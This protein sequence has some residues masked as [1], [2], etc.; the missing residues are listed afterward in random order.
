MLHITVPS[1]FIID[2]KAVTVN[3]QWRARPVTETRVRPGPCH[4]TRISRATNMPID[5]WDED[6]AARLLARFKHYCLDLEDVVLGSRSEVFTTDCLGTQEVVVKMESMGH[7]ERGM[8]LISL[9]IMSQILNCLECVQGR[10]EYK[11]AVKAETDA[12]VDL[13]QSSVIL[14]IGRLRAVNLQTSRPEYYRINNYLATAYRGI[15][16]FFSIRRVLCRLMDNDHVRWTCEML[17]AISESKQLRQFVVIA[18]LPTFVGKNSGA[19][20]LTMSNACVS[21]GFT[22]LDNLI[23]IFGPAV[24]QQAFKEGAVLSIIRMLH[25][26]TQSCPKYAIRTE[27]QMQRFLTSELLATTS[28]KAYNKH[29][30]D[31]TALYEVYQHH[32]VTIC[33]GPEHA[34]SV[35]GEPVIGRYV[36]VRKRANPSETWAKREVMRAHVDSDKSLVRH[37]D[38][39]KFPPVVELRTIDSYN[40]AGTPEYDQ[41]PELPD[42]HG[43]PMVT[44]MPMGD[45]VFKRLERYNDRNDMS[46]RGVIRYDPS[47]LARH[48]DR[49]PLSDTSKTTT[50]AELDDLVNRLVDETKGETIDLLKMVMDKRLDGEAEEDRVKRRWQKARDEEDWEKMSEVRKDYRRCEMVKIPYEG[51]GAWDESGRKNLRVL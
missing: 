41:F 4:Q 44:V 30:N 12:L 43:V 8:I 11:D 32:P 24:A 21:I 45:S 51:I 48:F 36:L 3:N 6:R 40:T 23:A 39:S 15:L 9:E 18:P 34:K 14:N 20:L 38:F 29:L 47:K 10:P 2:H 46:C 13:F 33:D 50:N 42:N 35:L 5:S 7:F 31:M 28:W 19:A 25:L 27:E 17:R 22:H 37:L 49:H 26:V 1:T 16:F